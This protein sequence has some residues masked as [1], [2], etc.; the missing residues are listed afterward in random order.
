MLRCSL[1]VFI[2]GMIWMII[3]FCQAA[4]RHRRCRSEHFYLMGAVICASLILCYQVLTR[5]IFPA[6]W[7]WPVAC[8]MCGGAVFGAFSNLCCMYNMG[9][10]AAALYLALSGLGFSISF[11]WSVAV[12]HEKMSWI[13]GV[14]LCCLAAA[15]I[16]SAFAGQTE[17]DKAAYTQGGS[18]TQKRLL[19]ALGATLCGGASQILIAYPSV[20]GFGGTPLPQLT[21]TLLI[22]LTYICVY[23]TVSVV[24]FR[25]SEKIDV[26]ALARSAVPWG[27]LAI[28][29]YAVLFVTLKYLGEI[30]R[31]GIAYALCGAVQLLLFTAATRVVFHDKLNAKQMAALALIIIGIFAVESG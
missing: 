3:S 8:C 6:E 20:A 22:M 7:S 9:F 11:L 5:T 2:T 29:S 10:G 13:N 15:G 27:V 30:G 31:A 1:F 23:F 28:L 24:T 16:L 17:E 25:R 18:L 12:W 21:K 14:G 4:A 19:A 26:W